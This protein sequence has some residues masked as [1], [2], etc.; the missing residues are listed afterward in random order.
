MDT[1]C[2]LQD[3]SQTLLHTNWVPWSRDTQWGASIRQGNSTA[4]LYQIYEY[5]LIEYPDKGIFHFRGGVN[6]EAG[7]IHVRLTVQPSYPFN[8]MMKIEDI[9][10]IPKMDCWYTD[11]TSGCSWSQQLQS[12]FSILKKY[13]FFP[14]KQ[15]NLSSLQLVIN[16][17]TDL[18]GR[19][20][21]LISTEVATQMD[22]KEKVSSKDFRMGQ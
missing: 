21:N 7:H 2:V 1:V 4:D 9:Y 6:C 13:P 19:N 22:G 5:L 16:I 10:H 17:N 8:V 15:N 12:S 3:T 14:N 20:L 11:I 18:I